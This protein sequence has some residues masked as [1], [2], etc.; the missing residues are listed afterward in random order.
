MSEEVMTKDELDA[1]RLVWKTMSQ[2]PETQ[3]A[4]SYPSPQSR[5]IFRRSYNGHVIVQ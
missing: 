2:D 5:Q 1:L 3:G 4:Y